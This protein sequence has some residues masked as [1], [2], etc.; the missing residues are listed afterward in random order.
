M[1]LSLRRET[2]TYNSTMSGGLL[3]AKTS[4]SSLTKFIGLDLSTVQAILPGKI[5]FCYLQQEQISNLKKQGRYQGYVNL[6][7]GYKPINGTKNQ[8]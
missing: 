5:Q 4:L 6:G 7:R 1:T 3:S 2:E 8:Q